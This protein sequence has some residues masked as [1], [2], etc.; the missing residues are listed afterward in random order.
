MKNGIEVRPNGVTIRMWEGADGYIGY[1]VDDSLDGPWDYLQN[2]RND[3]DGM[4]GPVKVKRLIAML[5]KF[6]PE[7]DVV[8]EI[9]T[10]GAQAFRIR[11]KYTDAISLV[12]APDDADALPPCVDPACECKKEFEDLGE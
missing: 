7:K 8:L 5:K 3:A 4:A 2:A 10:A 9:G 12:G 6:D 11:D 1:T